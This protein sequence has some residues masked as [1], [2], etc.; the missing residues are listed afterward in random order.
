MNTMKMRARSSVVEQPAHNRSVAGS[1][2]AGPTGGRGIVHKL[3][4]YTCG[5]S[6]GNP[7]AAAIGLVL[8][9][10]QGHIVE[11]AGELIGRATPAVAEYKA[12][13]SGAEKAAAY[14]PEEAVFLT[15]SHVLVNQITGISQPREPHLLH[16]NQLALECLGQLPKWRLN[17]LDPDANSGARRLAERAFR[18]RIR[19][20][21]ERTRLTRELSEL[22]AIL[23]LDELK[24]VEGF[25]RSLMAKAT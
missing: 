24:K 7:G 16:L 1:N 4:I 11:E 17:Y 21:R 19:S 23:S 6:R 10:D 8:L 20:E 14:A 22:L 5:V 13:I 15:D 25:I 18:E 3:F 9:D 12:L 2:P